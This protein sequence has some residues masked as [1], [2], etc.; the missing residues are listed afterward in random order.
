MESVEAE[1]HAKHV[2]TL[3]PLTHQQESSTPERP[4][5]STKEVSAEE[6]SIEEEQLSTNTDET[7]IETR[8]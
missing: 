2:T 5:D 6:V 8:Q 7:V 1:E 4:S 3:T